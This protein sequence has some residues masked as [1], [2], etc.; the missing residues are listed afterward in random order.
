MLCVRP[1]FATV[2]VRNKPPI[3]TFKWHIQ[4]KHIDNTCLAIIA[5]LCSSVIVASR[6]CRPVLPYCS[7]VYNGTVSYPSN[8]HHD[9]VVIGEAL[10]G[11]AHI[12]LFRF[13]IFYFDFSIIL[14]IFFFMLLLGC[15]Y[16]RRV[17]RGSIY[18]NWRTLWNSS[19][20][21]PMPP[22]NP[23]T[24]TSCSLDLGHRHNHAAWANLPIPKLRSCLGDPRQ[25][26][27]CT[28]AKNSRSTTE[29]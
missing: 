24:K 22:P 1:F 4:R 2:S 8:C 6:V 12:G 20:I 13:L 3:R 26:R 23:K 18:S 7:D 25:V 28:Q 10:A 15:L 11:F 21:M 16:S 14:F 27:G 17:T 9:F 5:C 29:T 19:V